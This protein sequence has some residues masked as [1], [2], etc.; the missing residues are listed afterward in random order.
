[1]G[2]TYEVGY[3][4]RIK[5]NEV[6]GTYSNRS[7]TLYISVCTHMCVCIVCWETRQEWSRVVNPDK[8]DNETSRSDN[9]LSSW[10][11]VDMSEVTVLHSQLFF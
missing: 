9:F 1:M 10:R 11:I 5:E 8:H 7:E 2:N 6:Q 4:D 3:C